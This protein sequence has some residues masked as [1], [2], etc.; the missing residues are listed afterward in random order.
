[1]TG[2]LIKKTFFDMWDNMLPM[3]VM[4]LGFLVLAAGLMY[5]PSLLIFNTVLS[6]VGLGVCIILIFVYAGAVS[7]AVGRF[8]DY[9]SVG[10]KEFFNRILKE[11]FLS[12]LV[13]GLAVAVGIIILLVT[14]PFYFNLGGFIGLGA[15]AVIFWMTVLFAFASQYYFAVRSRLDTN[16]KKIFKK[17]FIL[18]FD[19]TF[20][21]ISIA[22]GAAIIFTVSFF[23][24]FILPGISGIL[25][26]YQAA[27]KLRLYKYDYLEEN[28]E[29]DKKKIPW[30]ALLIEDKE[31]VGPRTLRGMIFPW[32]D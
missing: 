29:A 30:A 19:N 26:W 2:F 28:P 27:L 14:L 9:Q 4:N 10:F 21:S 20:F 22:I 31:K 23:T 12:S 11:T 3:V 16:I 25:L 8:A 15:M 32:K 24:A 17:C 6:M 7:H 5:V 18:F 13:F 1:M